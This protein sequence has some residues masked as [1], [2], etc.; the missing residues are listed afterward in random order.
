MERLRAQHH[1][2]GLRAP[3]RV[4]DL[5]A[6]IYQGK[7]AALKVFNGAYPR[8]WRVRREATRDTAWF[9]TAEGLETCR[10]LI[11]APQQD[12]AESI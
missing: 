5:L 10:R 6:K 7:R 8:E 3:D 11:P 9:R 1:W 12:M 2:S 4:Y